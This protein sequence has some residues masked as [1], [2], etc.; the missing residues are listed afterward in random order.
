MSKSAT[1]VIS[2]ALIF[3]AAIGETNET[4]MLTKARLLEG[5]P[6]SIQLMK[7]LKK[8]GHTSGVDGLVGV[9]IGLISCLPVQKFLSEEKL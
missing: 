9:F 1:N 6:P 3:A 7:E 2:A 4:L 8:I 5:T